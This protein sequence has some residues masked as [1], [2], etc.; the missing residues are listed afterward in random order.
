MKLCIFLEISLA[1]LTDS[2]GEYPFKNNDLPRNVT[3]PR[4]QREYFC[5]VIFITL[6]E[7][8]AKR[9]PLK[10]QQRSENIL[11]S[12]K[13][14]QFETLLSVFIRISLFTAV[15]ITCINW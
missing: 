13:Q 10:C 4:N 12:H 3:F 5:H 8:V 14:C 15:A 1:Q 9:I 6:I 11:H 7:I 2:P